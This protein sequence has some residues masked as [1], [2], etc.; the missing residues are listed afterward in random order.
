MENNTS[1]V[2]AGKNNTT[3]LRAGRTRLFHTQV[4]NIEGPVVQ[5]Y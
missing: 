1:P 4:R 3:D 5:K 2:R